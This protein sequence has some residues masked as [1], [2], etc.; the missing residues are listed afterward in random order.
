M[1]KAN[2]AAK[3]AE[4]A[5]AAQ[6]AERKADLAGSRPRQE[7]AERDEIGKGASSS[8]LRRSTNSSRK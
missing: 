5:V 8:H 4:Q 1:V 6:D 2:H 3:P 7:L